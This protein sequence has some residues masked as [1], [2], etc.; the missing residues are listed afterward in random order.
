M[1]EMYV[2]IDISNRVPGGHRLGPECSN[3]GFTQ[4]TGGSGSENSPPQAD[5]MFDRHD[6]QVIK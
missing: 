5:K 2:L 3:L 1:A 4:I 6:V